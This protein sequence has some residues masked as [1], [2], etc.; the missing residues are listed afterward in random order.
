MDC[1]SGRSYGVLIVSVLIWSCLWV[2]ES[3]GDLQSQSLNYKGNVKRRVEQK[4]KQKQKQQQQQQQ[5]KSSKNN[6]CDMYEGR[7]VQDDSY[8]LYNSSACPFIRKE[9]DCL[10]YGRPDHLYLHY[11]WQPIGC[12]LPSAYQA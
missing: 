2:A 10:K 12:S 9:F 6:V 1:G 4:Q 8:P 7:W 3:S 5:G 11:R